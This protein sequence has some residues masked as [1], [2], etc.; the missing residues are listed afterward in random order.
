MT[1]IQA[2]I[3]FVNNN[4]NCSDEMQKQLSN[5][6]CSI[7]VVV[8]CG[9]F[10]ISVCISTGSNKRMRTHTVLNLVV[11]H[12]RVYIDYCDGAYAQ[13]MNVLKAALIS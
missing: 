1:I 8:D 3:A 10:S 7:N 13:H 11:E 4:L 2:A 9:A 6:E 5:D 12:K